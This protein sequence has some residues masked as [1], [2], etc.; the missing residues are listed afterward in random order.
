[1]K[2]IVLSVCAAVALNA[3]AE[4]S[5]GSQASGAWNDHEGREWLRKMGPQWACGVRTP[6]VLGVSAD[7]ARTWPKRKILEGKLDLADPM[8]YWYC[9]V[10]MLELPD[11]LLLAY[12]AEGEL[13][14]MK[15]VSVPKA[16]LPEK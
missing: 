9:Y 3:R 1:M 12:S 6:L 4:Q 16:W 8:A 7:G 5:V 15:V 2:R 13:N 10:A 11:R 14:A